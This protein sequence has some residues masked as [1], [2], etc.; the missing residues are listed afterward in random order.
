MAKQLPTPGHCLLC[1]EEVSKRT[2]KTHMMKKHQV[3][4]GVSRALILVDTPYPSPYYLML[5]VDPEATLQ[6][7]DTVLRRVWLECC[8]HLSSF[9][10]DDEEIEMTWE[11]LLATKKGG[12]PSKK[13][14]LRSILTPGT[15][16]EYI[17]DY[18][19]TT[20]LRLRVQDIM[21]MNNSGKAVDVL[22]MND[23]PAWKCSECG[24]P[25]SWHYTEE[26]DDTVLCGECAENPDLDECYLLP[27]TNSPRTGICAYE[28]GC[29]DD[30]ED[31]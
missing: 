28:G 15:S 26:E 10:I 30:L 20:E 1:K 23:R 21:N 2:I 27:I 11:D 22:G 31:E 12:K 24:E 13:N 7:I 6:D 25:A 9:I 14:S 4:N 17:Y 18:G 5:S 19:S 3:Q 16:F 8:G 29:F